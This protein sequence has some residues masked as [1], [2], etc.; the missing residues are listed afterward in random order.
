MERKRRVDLKRAF[1]VLKVCLP[2]LAESDK[3]SKLMI[4]DAATGF[5][6]RLKSKEL[7]LS[8][9]R[10]REQKKNLLLKK[11]LQHMKLPRYHQRRA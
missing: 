3:A 10:D 6:R 11:K 7:G 4:L 2:E 5:C 8:S 1:D 9:E